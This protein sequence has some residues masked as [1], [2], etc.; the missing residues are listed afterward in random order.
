MRETN[1]PILKRPIKA[2]PGMVRN[3][4]DATSPYDPCVRALP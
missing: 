2:Y 3:A 4:L 1:D